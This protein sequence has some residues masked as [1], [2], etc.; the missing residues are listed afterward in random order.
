[1]YKNRANICHSGRDIAIKPIFKMAAAAI[2]Y[3][4][5]SLFLAY[6]RI[7]IVVLYVHVKV[8][9]PNSTGGWVI[10]FCQNSK[11]RLS[12]ILNYCV[13]ILDK[14]QSLAGDRKPVFKFRVDPICSFE[15]IVNRKFSKFGLNAYSGHQN[16]R[17]GGFWPL[18]IIFH[19]RDPKRH[20]VGGK[21]VLWAIVRRN[22]SSGMTRT[23]CEV[24]TNNKTNKG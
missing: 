9:K 19:H 5:S 21:H 7:W 24:Y 16:L 18:N 10:R 6:R 15:D 23:R 3:L 22:R 14:T 17:F 2:L 13:A 8:R 12:A 11:W 1:M 20:Y 4:L